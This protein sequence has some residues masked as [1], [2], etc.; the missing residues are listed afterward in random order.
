[1]W[2]SDGGELVL[3][4]L[5]PLIPELTQVVLDNDT[6]RFAGARNQGVTLPPA[7]VLWFS[8]DREGANYYGRSRNE[9]V[10]NVW[11]AWN[12]TLA[13]V[14]Q[15]TR[16]AAGVTPMVRYPPGRSQ[17]ASGAEVD[18]FEI[19]KRI[20]QHLGRGEGIAWPTS[21]HA[22]AEDLVRQGVDIDKLYAWQIVM[23]EAK[24]RHG[25][26]FERLMKLLDTYL[27]R[28]W[29][30]P[31]RAVAEGRFGT[32]ADASAHAEIAIVAAEEVLLDIADCLNWYV[33]DRMLL[34]NWG[35]SAVGQVRAVPEPLQDAQRTFFRDV[36]GKVL[37]QPATVDLL[38]EL[39]D[40]EAMI[41]Q[42]GLP[43]RVRA[44]NDPP[45]LPELPD[46]TGPMTTALAGIYASMRDSLRGATP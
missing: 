32:K 28:G 2:E 37:T 35:P 38:L 31:E 3:D 4:K 15:Y 16:K 34:F 7:K 10:R 21:L 11:S 44:E 23:L 42:A 12:D 43:S 25:A 19:A 22:W 33:V 6:G 30:V 29:L 26:E 13:R 40:I 1:M 46:D 24:G 45:P 14:G 27:I 17:D 36:L 39:V 5:K 18:N 9:N 41:Q 8:Y 20:L